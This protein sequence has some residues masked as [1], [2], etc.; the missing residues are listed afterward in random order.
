MNSATVR[1]PKVKIVISLLLI[2]YFL[3][4]CQQDKGPKVTDYFWPL[5]A[6]NKFIYEFVT[7]YGGTRTLEI[8]SIVDNNEEIKVDIKETID[9]EKIPSKYKQS[10]NNYQYKIYKKKNLIK[11]KNIKSQKYDI[12]Y[13]GPLKKGTKWT[14][15]AYSKSISYN[16]KGSNDSETP[17]KE[18]KGKGIIDDIRTMNVLGKKTECIVI[19]YYFAE[20]T[21]KQIFCKG[22]GPIGIMDKGQ[23]LDKLIKIEN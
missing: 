14:T 6:G 3:G 21:A 16:D 10:T 20:S 5:K 1:Q 9:I 13:K 12:L 11:M 8:I 19:G 17:W 22:I 15:I 7:S 18:I 4:G 2:V 23:M